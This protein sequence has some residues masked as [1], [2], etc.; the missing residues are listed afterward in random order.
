MKT[1]KIKVTYTFIGEVLVNAENKIEAKKIVNENFG[2]IGQ[3]PK[4][5]SSNDVIVDWNMPI[6]PSEI[7]IS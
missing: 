7:K 6:H 3:V 4:I 2:Y 1:Y 5:P